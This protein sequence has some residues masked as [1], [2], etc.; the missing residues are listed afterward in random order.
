MRR[1]SLVLSILATFAALGIGY[2]RRQGQAPKACDFCQRAMC[3]GTAY[4]VYLSFGRTKHACCPRCGALYEKQHPGSVQRTTVR[5]FA[6]DYD[7]HAEDATYVEGSDFSHCKVGMLAHDQEGSTFTVCY[8]RCT[9][10]VVA[11]AARRSAVEFEA[12]HGGKL[13]SFEELLRE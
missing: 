4:T 6:T 10:S 7:I 5:D 8:D 13:I 9:P 3:E 12:A 2:A 1:R 11:F